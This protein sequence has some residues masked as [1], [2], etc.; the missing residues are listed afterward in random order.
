MTDTAV[1]PVVGLYSVTVTACPGEAVPVQ[2]KP[3]D[4]TGAP[5]AGMVMPVLRAS[6]VNGPAF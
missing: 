6:V 5:F 4:G 1:A 3:A 2:L